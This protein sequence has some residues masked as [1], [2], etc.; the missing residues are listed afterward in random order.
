MCEG[1]VLRLVT[2]Y[3]LIPKHEGQGRKSGW[4]TLFVQQLIIAKAMWQN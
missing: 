4:F 1:L 2:N 3:S